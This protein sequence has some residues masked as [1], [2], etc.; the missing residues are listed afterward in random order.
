[1]VIA[2]ISRLTIIIIYLDIW[3]NMPPPRCKCVDHPHSIIRIAMEIKIMTISV[4]MV[5]AAMMSESLS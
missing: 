4:K 1:M 2:E 5:A 3:I